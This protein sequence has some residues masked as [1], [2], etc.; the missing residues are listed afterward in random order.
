MRI[1]KH[2]W[3]LIIAVLISLSAISS[4]MAEEINSNVTDIPTLEIT[5]DETGCYSVLAKDHEGSIIFT[6][7]GLTGKIE[8]IIEHSYSN[9]F[10]AATKSCTHIPCNHEIVTGGINHVIDWDTDICTMITNDF[11]RCA[12]CDQILGIVPGSTTVVGTHP[13]H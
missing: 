5:R 3:V 9:I 11:Y 7:K 4:V 1:G 13:A 8:D 2:F 6:E 12:C 10:R